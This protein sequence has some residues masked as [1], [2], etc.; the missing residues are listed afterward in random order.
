MWNPLMECH[1]VK[2]KKTKQQQQ[3]NAHLNSSISKLLVMK[4]A[5]TEMKRFVE[6]FSF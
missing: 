6:I 3:G 2:N 1:V 4:L 5:G